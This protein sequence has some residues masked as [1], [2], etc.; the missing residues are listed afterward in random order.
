MKYDEYKKRIVDERQKRRGIANLSTRSM[1]RRIKRKENQPKRV[2]FRTVLARATKNQNKIEAL[3][4]E[5][6]IL[7]MRQVEIEADI[8][9]MKEYIDRW[10]R[11]EE[12]DN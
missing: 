2:L 4:K 12:S 3:K 1:R 9:T 11:E 6:A 8:K 5:I 10:V 7:K